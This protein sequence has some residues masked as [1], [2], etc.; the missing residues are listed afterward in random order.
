MV[1]KVQRDG[2]PGFRVREEKRT[3]AKVEKG[4]VDFF[5]LKTPFLVYMHVTSSPG[6]DF[7]K[8]TWATTSPAIC[9]QSSFSHNADLEWIN[10][11][12][13]YR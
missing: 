6:P 12:Y 10:R 2:L 7:Y 4:N 3:F 9:F 13:V 5:Q 1:L 11:Y 8:A